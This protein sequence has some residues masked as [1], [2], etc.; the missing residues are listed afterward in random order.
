MNSPVRIVVI[1]D[2]PLYRDG[3]V[4]TLS[5]NDGL[6]VVAEGASAD[7][8]IRLCSEHRPDI[9]LLDVSMPGGGIDALGGVLSASPDTRALMLTVSESEGDVFA[10]LEKGAKGYILKGVDG[11]ELITIIGRVASGE[12]HVAPA[13]AASLLTSMRNAREA[14]TPA[15]APATPTTLSTREQGILEL[16]SQGKSNKEIGRQLD[17]QEKTVKHYLTAIFQKLHARNRVEAAM[18]ARE[19]FGVGD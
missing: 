19:R 10:S 3:V 14:H 1:D 15:A 13:L 6:E 11:H 18:I 7:D 17:L 2:H 9:V 16:L 12:S 5:E 4:R 8:A